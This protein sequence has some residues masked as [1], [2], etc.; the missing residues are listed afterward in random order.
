MDEFPGLK[1]KIFSTPSHQLLDFLQEL[2][3]EDIDVK[4]NNEDLAK[5]TCS[6]FLE[7]MDTNYSIRSKLNLIKSFY[8]LNNFLICRNLKPKRLSFM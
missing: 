2:K 8:K 6:V 4:W 5:K 7:N 3:I 1:E